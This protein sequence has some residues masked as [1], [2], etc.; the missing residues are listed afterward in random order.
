[1]KMSIILYLKIVFVNRHF[2]LKHQALLKYEK[3]HF[4]NIILT[5][6]FSSVLCSA[7]NLDSGMLA[8]DITNVLQT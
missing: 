7:L 6:K 5:I 2:F 4:N 3:Y 8:I 1:M